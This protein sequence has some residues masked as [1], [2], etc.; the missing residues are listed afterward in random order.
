MANR[1]QLI[2][3]AAVLSA[4]VAAVAFTIIPKSG[5]ISVS[6][7]VSTGGVNPVTAEIADDMGKVRVFKDVDDFIKQAAKVNVINGSQVVAYS[8]VNQLAL[9]PAVFT[10]DIVKRTR[11]TI[12]SYQKN[13][14]SNTATSTALAVAIA[15]LPSATPGEVAFKA[16][17]Q[18]Q[19]DAVDALKTF[20]SAEVTRLTALLPPL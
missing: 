8:F 14:L 9:E 11:A 20:L 19:K 17:K 18:A 13:V 1:A 16:E 10:G 4:P 15:L 7:S 3:L 5:D 6:A 12:T 2:R